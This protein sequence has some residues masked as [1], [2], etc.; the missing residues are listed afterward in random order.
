[1]AD[2]PRS[3]ADPMIG[4]RAPADLKAALQEA[5]DEAD[6]SLAAECVRRLRRSF[7]PTDLV[8]D[9]VALVVQRSGMLYQDEEVFTFVLGTLSNVFGAEAT[10]KAATMAHVMGMMFQ[11]EM[12]A[13][14]RGPS[15]PKVRV[16]IPRSAVDELKEA[17]AK[18][19]RECIVM[20]D[21][22]FEKVHPDAN[23]QITL[24]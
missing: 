4:I 2:E 12:Q 15:V 6:R 23:I 8:D 9:A 11:A 21:E 10:D 14:R 1:M 16:T 19:E 13:K 3:G 24:K 18:I 17:V 20:D 5:A 22:E 7:D